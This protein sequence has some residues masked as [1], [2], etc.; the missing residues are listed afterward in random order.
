[1]QE[2]ANEVKM[3]TLSTHN[4]TDIIDDPIIASN[5][6]TSVDPTPK[7][8]QISDDGNVW[9]F[10]L[11]ILYM[12]CCIS[13]RR[14]RP[15]SM[16]WRQRVE[17]IER[18]EREKRKILMQQNLRTKRIIAKDEQGN[19][20]LGSI[21][22]SPKSLGESA[23]ASLKRDDLYDE[24]D[25]ACVICLEPFRVGDVVTWS[26]YA[27]DCSHFFHSECIEP[28]VGEK[29]QDDCPSCRTSLIVKQPP[30]TGTDD[31][32]NDESESPSEVQEVREEEEPEDSV[33]H[34]VHGLI[35][36][37][38]RKASR[39]AL[40]P[41]SS[42]SFDCGSSRG[43]GTT[44]DEEMSTSDSLSVP[45]PLRRVASTTN[46]GN[47]SS[48]SL[49]SL[50]EPATL[51]RSNSSPSLLSQKLH[52]LK[53]RSSLASDDIETNS[54]NRKSDED[55]LGDHHMAVNVEFEV[56]KVATSSDT[57]EAKDEEKAL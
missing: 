31:N 57:L 10:S 14:N 40:L 54:N 41:A 27:K 11:V 4:D 34:I 18:K 23:K 50:A 30:T 5:T 22:E 51:T 48:S 47:T 15:Q 39:Y 44:A 52:C 3:S 43:S 53:R 37:A 17:K 35:S 21:K 32:E 16:T 1:M 45:S 20:T 25:H 6:T 46:S 36:R 19:W 13:S 33:F 28:W 9:A 55:V 56:S 29:G 8:L 49:S 26:R 38:A 7:R 12:I 42:G 24:D 2:I